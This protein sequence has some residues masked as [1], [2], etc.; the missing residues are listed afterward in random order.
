MDFNYNNSFPSLPQ[1]TK[2]ELNYQ[3][4]WVIRTVFAASFFSSHLNQK[5]LFLNLF[6]GF[7][8]TVAS[9]PPHYFA[10]KQTG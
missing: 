9:V 10:S 5:V 3:Q 1:L 6:V 8:N 4:F 7:R 2:E